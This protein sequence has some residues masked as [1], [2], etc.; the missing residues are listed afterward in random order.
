MKRV[1]YILL[2]CCSFFYGKTQEYIIPI[3]PKSNISIAATNITLPFF[4]DFAYY[5]F[6][7]EPHP[8]RWITQGVNLNNTFGIDAPTIGVATFD[9]ANKN[10][11]LYF[12]DNF[13][14]LPMDTLTT[15]P[16][17]FQ[18]TSEKQNLT[19]SFQVQPNV[20]NA[21]LKST[22]SLALHFFSP[23]TQEWKTVWS[24]RVVVK[25]SLLITY[26]IF[27]RDTLAEK[28][29]KKFY[30]I[31]IPI[32][33]PEFL[34]DG[35]QF[36]FIN[37]VTLNAVSNISG[38]LGATAFWH[39][40][41]VHLYNK[42]FEDDIYLEDV[43][44]SALPTTL[45]RDYTAMPWKHLKNNTMAT[46]DQISYSEIGTARLNY[47]INNLS[48]TDVACDITVN[49][50]PSI[51]AP[52]IVN[53][54]FVTTLTYQR[55]TN[56][57]DDVN[58]DLSTIP[59]IANVD[60]ISFHVELY[61]G[62]YNTENSQTMND[63]VK[64]RQNFLDYYAYDDGTAENG[65]GLF[66]NGVTNAAVAIKHHS[67]IQDT[68]RGVW[69][70][71][72]PSI[73]SGNFKTR[74]RL[75]VWNEENGLPGTLVYSK[76]NVQ[77]QF[78]GRNQ[79]VFYPFDSVVVV[80]RNFYIGWIQ[81]SEVMLNVGF[82]QNSK[83]SSRH[84]VKTSSNA[85]WGLSDYH[86]KGAVMLRP[87]FR[88]DLPYED[89]PTHVLPSEKQNILSVEIYPNFTKNGFYISAN[90]EI[91]IENL[92]LEIY[93]I[94]G[95]R[96]LFTQ[97]EHYVDINHLHAGYYFIRLTEKTTRKNKVLRLVKYE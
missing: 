19:L 73:D 58:I 30:T 83:F 9:N 1:L 4:D 56:T 55:L 64:F 6:F 78:T 2:C 13:R 23:T 67:Y 14:S 43:A 68:L 84:Y 25:D 15:L 66:G 22:D 45:L 80:N 69:I 42:L 75:A 63:T 81:Q 90:Q 44:I 76:S 33:E 57:K 11:Q 7:S 40:D 61:I 38:F 70:Y 77:P 51:P 94:T 60:T 62:N 59:T 48:S 16:L 82:D 53:P 5:G 54:L 65:Y 32:E 29:E 79:Y 71:F 27:N 18:S 8:N 37:Y 34:E 52:Q 47:G 89:H 3:I 26:R 41:V 21:A 92:S 97:Q 49:L 36:R 96:F 20:F 91:N 39:L 17:Q 74:F 95:R 10:G 93:D 86:D 50:L 31:E 24:A 46:I 35:F 88:K 85:L 72:N 28:L 87:S 12:M